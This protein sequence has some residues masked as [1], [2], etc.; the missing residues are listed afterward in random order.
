MYGRGRNRK[1]K[2][3]RKPRKRYSYRGYKMASKSEVVLAMAMDEQKIPWI[4]EP[5]PWDWIPPKRKYTVDFKVMRS[6]GSYF[7]VEYKGYFRTEDKTKMAA[8][9]KQYPDRDVRFVFAN[10][11]KPVEGAQ[12]RKDGTKLTNAEWAEK[13]GYLWADNCIPKEWMT[14]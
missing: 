8:I 13:N 1:P 14:C 6:D 12:P 10:P 9:K 11:H 7:Y 2:G 4:Y 3:K 5:E